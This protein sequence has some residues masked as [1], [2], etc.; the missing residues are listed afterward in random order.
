MTVL[1]T[2]NSWSLWHTKEG[3]LLS[4]S[5][6]RWP[7][8]KSSTILFSMS[9]MNCV[10]QLSVVGCTLEHTW[11]NHLCYS[12]A[13]RYQPGHTKFSRIFRNFPYNRGDPQSASP[14]SVNVRP[15]KI[16]LSYT[17][18]RLWQSKHCLL[19]L[20][21]LLFSQ[22][23]TP[24]VLPKQHLATEKERRCGRCSSLAIFRGW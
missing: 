15:G 20:G 6:S 19:Q 12:G 18:A 11:S 13:L 22:C 17:P 23:C 14:T 10:C 3:I 7:M 9:W 16:S 5:S 8:L 24:A 4:T 2:K 21:N 1:A